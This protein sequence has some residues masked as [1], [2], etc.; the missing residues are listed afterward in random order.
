MA[1]NPADSQKCANELAGK[2]PFAVIS[3]LNF[4]G[5]HFPIY[6]AG[7]HQRRGRH[8]DHRRRL[9]GAA[10]STR[11]APAA[12]A[13]ASTPALVYA[14]TQELEGASASRSRGPTRLRASSATTTSRRSRSTCS[15][16]RC[17][18]TRE[19]AG[20]DPRPR[21]T[22]AC[23]SSR[24]APDVTPQVTQVLDFKPDVIIFSAQGADCWNLV[25]GLGRARLDPGRDP[26]DPVRRLHRLR[27]DEGRRRPGQGRLLRRRRRRAASP[28]PTPSTNPRLKLEAQTYLDE[29]RRVRHAATPTSPRASAAQGWSV[30]DDA[31]GAG[32]HRRQ[33]AA[34][35]SRPRRFT[36]QMAGTD[37]QP[38]LRL[39]A[40]RLRRRPAALH[41][42]VQLQGQ[43]AA[44]GRRRRCSAIV[45]VF[46]GIDLIAGTEL[47]PG[48]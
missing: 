12:A 7:R 23:R 37:G 36:A 15:R 27:E 28:T 38:H 43:P 26:A 32:Q 3:T 25:D 13:S 2:N 46:S 14:A 24:P 45:P 39:G 29:G 41:R 35:S 10:A 8:A 48:P 22:S 4:F 34:R 11:S 20:I 21:S 18:A 47:K 30:D 5:N 19:L 1:I 16:A 44:V 6:D 9:H 42:G 33:R 40:L 31:L 17:P